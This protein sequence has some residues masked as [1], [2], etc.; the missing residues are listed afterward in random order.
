M[1]NLSENVVLAL[2]FSGVLS[3]LC[4]RFLTFL[5]KSRCSKI[6]CCW[7]GIKCDRD[8]IE[9]KD[10]ELKVLDEPPPVE[11]PKNLVNVKK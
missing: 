4:V 7:G 6:N 3:T 5:I 10:I 8:T 9:S 11:I 2:I 1:I